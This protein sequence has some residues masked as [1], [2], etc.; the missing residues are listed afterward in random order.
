MEPPQRATNAT[1]RSR[2]LAATPTGRHAQ[3]WLGELID[4]SR[5]LDLETVDALFGDL[6][7]DGKNAYFR[8]FSIEV[9][10]DHTS[11]TPTPASS[12]SPTTSHAHGR[13]D[14]CGRGRTDARGHRHPPA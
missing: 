9:A 1:R 13:A 2:P 8:D 6:V 3:D 5:P 10:V 4:L 7:A 11:R 12:G 14:P